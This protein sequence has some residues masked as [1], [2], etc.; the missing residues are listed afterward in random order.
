MFHYV[1]NFGFNVKVTDCLVNEYGIDNETASE[2]V[3]QLH[4]RNISLLRKKGA[5]PK[6]LADVI[7]AT[8]GGRSSDELW[9]PHG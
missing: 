6:D 3:A 1:R 7:M 5:T 4:S 9:R 8:T 2:L